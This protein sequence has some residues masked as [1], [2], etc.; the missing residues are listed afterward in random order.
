[1]VIRVESE[2][3][4]GTESLALVAPLYLPNGRKNFCGVSAALSLG[5]SFSG[6]PLPLRAQ[7]NRVQA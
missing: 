4:D 3:S 6:T 1:M 5:G 7:P 2:R